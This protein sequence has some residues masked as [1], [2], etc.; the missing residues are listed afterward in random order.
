MNVGRF[1][2]ITIVACVLSLAVLIA[3]PEDALGAQ[4]TG[5]LTLGNPEVVRNIR[6]FLW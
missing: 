4:P 6:I 2:L 5:T 3:A 1:I